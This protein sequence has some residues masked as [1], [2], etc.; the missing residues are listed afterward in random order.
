MLLEKNGKAS[1]TKCAR[2]ISI[3]FFFIAGA[4]KNQ[5]AAGIEH[6]PPEEVAGGCFAEPLA[7]ALL[8]KARSL[9]LGIKEGGKHSYKAGYGRCAAVKPVEKIQAHKHATKA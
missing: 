6:L 2:H 1:S 3:R 8:C 7:G 5:R 9:A 4:V